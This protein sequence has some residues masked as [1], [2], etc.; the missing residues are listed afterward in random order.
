V[1]L[2]HLVTQFAIHPSAAGLMFFQDTATVGFSPLDLW[3][4]MG[5][6]AKCVVILLFIMSIWSLAVIFDRALYF[7]ALQKW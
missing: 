1:I 3:H 4:N 6:L 2:A 7:N 5:L